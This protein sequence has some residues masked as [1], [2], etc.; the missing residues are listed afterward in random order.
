M[1]IQATGRVVRDRRGLEI[2]IERRVVASLGAVEA[3]LR[4]EP[5]ADVSLTEVDGA[6]AVFLRRRIES[7]REAGEI[8]PELE[9]AL[10]RMIAQLTDAAAPQLSG[11]VPS[12]QPYYERI[13]MDGDPVSWPPS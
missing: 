8:G 2:L 1:A 12:Q 6:T 7:A 5:I 11:Y 3:W 10:D 9:F 13:A 4:A